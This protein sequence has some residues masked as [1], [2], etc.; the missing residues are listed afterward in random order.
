MK[1]AKVDVVYI[2]GY[3]NDAGLMMRQ[4]RD[5]GFKADFVSG[6]ALNTAEFWSISGPAGEGMRFS[7]AASAINL[8]SAK[9]VVAKF[10]AENY[11]PE[12]YTL[13][14]YASVQA[15]AAAAAG[16]GGT[17]GAKMADWLRK[18][19]VKTAIGDLT[20]DDKGDLTKVN[21]A[22]FLWHDGKYAQEPIN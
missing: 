15:F 5:Q 20:W 1:E 18:N 19:S 11:E 13:S 2:G 14:S 12:G 7:D 21:Y 3:H 8:D 9:D 22:W 10:R 6:D 4:A 17:D 16:T